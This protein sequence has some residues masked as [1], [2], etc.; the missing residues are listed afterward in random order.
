MKNLCLVLT[1]V[2]SALL[3]SCGENMAPNP[4]PPIPGNP[5]AGA[6]A[7]APQTVAPKAAVKKAIAPKVEKKPAAPRTETIQ[8]TQSVLSTETVVS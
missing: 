2:G 7:I 5:V 4:V 6:T 8:K 1:V 3:V